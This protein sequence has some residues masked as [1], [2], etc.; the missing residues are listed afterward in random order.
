MHRFALAPLLAIGLLMLFSA[1][2]SS[3]SLTVSYDLSSGQLLD[4]GSG[5]NYEVFSGFVTM[6]LNDNLAPTTGTL[7]WTSGTLLSFTLTAQTTTGP[8]TLFTNFALFSPRV[9]GNV[10]GMFF[11]AT[12]TGTGGGIGSWATSPLG[13]LNLFAFFSAGSSGTITATGYGFIGGNVGTFTMNNVLGTEVHRTFVP[14][15]RTGTLLASGL[16]M[17]ALGGVLVA[18]RRNR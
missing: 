7:A 16:V 4:V 3:A 8:A 18:R 17:A 2:A 9:I 12:G 14:E 15:P 10:G 11:T 6:R 5:T 1:P 13:S